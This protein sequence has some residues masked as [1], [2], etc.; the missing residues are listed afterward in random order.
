MRR[1]LFLAFVFSLH[2]FLLNSSLYADDPEPTKSDTQQVAETTFKLGAFPAIEKWVKELGRGLD[3]CLDRLVVGGD[4]IQLGKAANG[5]VGGIADGFRDLRVDTS[6][7]QTFDAFESLGRRLW[8]PDW[9]EKVSKATPAEVKPYFKG[10][11]EYD[12]NVFLEPKAPKRRDEAVWVWT[13]G[14][15][16]NLPF[17]DEKQYRVGAVY[18]ARFTEFTKY[19]EHDDVG[20]TLGAVAD[21]KLTDDIYAKVTEEFIQDAARA[22]TRTAKKVEYTQNRVSPT[23]GYHWGDW[24][25][26][27]QYWNE[28]RDFESAIYR[29]FSYANNGFL[30][31]I[32]RTLFPNFRGLVDYSFSHYDYAADE[33]RVGW[34]HQI[35]AGVTGQLSERSNLL[36]RMGYQKR[37]YKAHD[38]QFD[39][40]VWDVRLVHR[41]TSRTTLDFSFERTIEESAFTNNRAYDEKSFRAAGTYLFTQKL[42]GRAGT[43][44]LRREYEREAFTG[45]VL[46]KRR[47]NIGRAFVGI[48][49]IFRP[50]FIV[51]L[52]YR[53]DR[54]NSNNSNFDYTNNQVV[55]GMTMPL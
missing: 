14:V 43:A 26:E 31:T 54:S 52:D 23:V 30:T 3:W 28:I 39:I 6:V 16:I 49:Y 45:A 41:L 34:Y 53:Y 46:V 19:D 40:P 21:L 51:N 44:F 1:A 22:G 18:E 17:G 47:D 13:P 36:A 8:L 11:F 9:K 24:T 15:A 7:D 27:G 29:A 2:F 10:S 33:T 32:Y 4:S 37:D 25:L 50:W 35:R 20:Q 12:S 48:D 5:V 42:R 55:L 38:T